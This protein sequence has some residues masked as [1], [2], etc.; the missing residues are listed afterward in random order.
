MPPPLQRALAGRVE[1]L[2]RLGKRRWR[3]TIG[4]P[5]EVVGLQ[6]PQVLNVLFGNVSLQTGVLVTEVDW[7]PSLVAALPG[8]AFGIAGVRR[9]LPG[10]AGRALLCTALKPVGLT[11]GE[12]SGL[13]QRF[14][15][16]GVDIVKDDHGLAD[17]ATAPFA[18]R[19]G[20]IQQAV[21]RGAR[22]S[23]RECLYLPHLTGPIDELP[24]RLELLRDEG[25][26]GALVSP[27]LLGLD[28][29]RW[30]AAT[31]GLVL[32]A[33]PTWSGT[34][35]G[36]RHGISPAVVFGDLLR[37]LGADGVIYVNPGGRFPVTVEV[38]EAINERL[39]RPFAGK[40]PAFPVAGGGM[41]VETLGRWAARY[42]PDTV[43]LVGGSLY[44]QEDPEEASRQLLQ[45]LAWQG[46]G[47]A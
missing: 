6:V 9:L 18:S 26:R 8:P 23:G 36:A 35:F 22:E 43:F 31:S 10:A 27:F 14:A 45:V 29:L 17:Q 38:C 1:Q 21:R 33:H 11:I 5:A 40:T 7:P 25:V 2:E 47:L 16:G 19:V 4:Y 37:L 12:L 13:A 30:L 34:L 41:Q 46:D 39:R 44:A 28:T 24:R 15:R 20:R 3:A 42:G 32:F